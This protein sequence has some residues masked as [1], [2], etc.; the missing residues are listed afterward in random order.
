M[1][2]TDD[3]SLAMQ[4]GYPAWLVL[5]LCKGNKKKREKNCKTSKPG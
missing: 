5:R 4:L 1:T 3:S 2:T